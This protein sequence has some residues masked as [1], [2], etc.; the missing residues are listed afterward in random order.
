MNGTEHYNPA[1][2]RPEKW[3]ILIVAVPLIHKAIVLSALSFGHSRLICPDF[4][5]A[6][7]HVTHKCSSLKLMFAPSILYYNSFF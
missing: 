4:S 1:P 7:H 2:I 5:V 3:F 6:L